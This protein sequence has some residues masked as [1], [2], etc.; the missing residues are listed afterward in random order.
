MKKIYEIPVVEINN[1]EPVQLIAD[2]FIVGG[3][4]NVG[5]NGETEEAPFQGIDWME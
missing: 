3:E 5:N 1:V 2:S 4:A